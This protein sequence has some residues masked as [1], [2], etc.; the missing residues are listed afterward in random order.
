[1]MSRRWPVPLNPVVQD[2]Y[3]LINFN[4]QD[5]MI[6]PAR[7]GSLDKFPEKVMIQRITKSAQLLS[8]Y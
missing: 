5:A 7:P 6:F 3:L 4:N 2:N 1:M 8:D